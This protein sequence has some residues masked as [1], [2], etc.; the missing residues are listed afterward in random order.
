MAK[1]A[2][3]KTAR[4]NVAKPREDR[5]VGKILLIFLDLKLGKCN[6]G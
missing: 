5:S 6:F 1:T 4:K 3:P 2:K